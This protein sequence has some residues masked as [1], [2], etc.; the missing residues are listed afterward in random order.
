MN[1]APPVAEAG[2]GSNP[3]LSA[4]GERCL[5]LASAPRLAAVAAILVFFVAGAALVRHQADSNVTRLHS[6]EGL[7]LL[8]GTH[9]VSKL[10][11]GG[12]G[13]ESGRRPD[14]S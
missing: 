3:R 6:D 10:G 11:G 2:S 8:D 4:L 1:P 5:A 13:E 9:T 14:G 7:T 12:G